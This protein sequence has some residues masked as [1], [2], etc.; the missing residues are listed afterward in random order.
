[1]CFSVYAYISICI[2]MFAIPYISCGFLVYV[3]TLLK[4]LKLV[5]QDFFHHFLPYLLRQVSQLNPELTDTS[6][7]AN[8]LFHVSSSEPWS[9]R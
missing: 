8:Q 4:S 9:Y 2:H 7:I 1:M 3:C 5:S 6:S